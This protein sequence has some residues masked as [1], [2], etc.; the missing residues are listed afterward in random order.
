MGNSL[1]F[2]TTLQTIYLHIL[3]NSVQIFLDFHHNK[4]TNIR[5]QL[6]GR[7]QLRIQDR[8]REFSYN[9][10]HPGFNPRHHTKKCKDCLLLFY[11]MSF[12]LG[13]FS[14]HVR[15]VPAKARRGHRNWRST[16]TNQVVGN[17]PGSS[18]EQQTLSTAEPSLQ[19]YF[20]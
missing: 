14:L 15:L 9:S 3:Y 19:P 8:A 6:C 4:K 18:E 13:E 7:V 10:L 17:K 12:I 16:V 1:K 20:W 5:P 2:F 11:F